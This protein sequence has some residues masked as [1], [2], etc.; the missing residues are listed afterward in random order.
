MEV[1]RLFSSFEVGVR[2]FGVRFGE[3]RWWGIGFVNVDVEIGD[4]GGEV[5]FKEEVGGAATNA[6]ANDCYGLHDAVLSGKC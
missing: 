3:V 1:G 2:A 4:V 6:G 5:L